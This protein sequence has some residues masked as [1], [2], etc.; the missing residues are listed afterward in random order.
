MTA[1]H[2]SDVDDEALPGT[3]AYEFMKSI[4]RALNGEYTYV[5]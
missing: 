4:A 1:V 3:T 2:T 5:C